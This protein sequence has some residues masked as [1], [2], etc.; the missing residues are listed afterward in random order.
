MEQELL[1]PDQKRLYK[2]LFFR[3][4]RAL[5]ALF[6][7]GLVIGLLHK[8]DY[9]VAGILAILTLPR[10]WQTYQRNPSSLYDKR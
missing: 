5:I 6:I 7:A 10:W 9:I 3:F 8:H 4:L 1:I 2:E